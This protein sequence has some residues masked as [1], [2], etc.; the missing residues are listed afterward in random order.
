MLGI[1]EAKQTYNDNP[2]DPYVILPGN[3]AIE[4]RFSDDGMITA[5]YMIGGHKWGSQEFI[6]GVA[7]SQEVAK[8]DVLPRKEDRVKQTP[9]LEGARAPQRIGNLAPRRIGRPILR[10][11]DW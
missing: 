3:A 11:E 2:A 6:Q 5:A 10:R 9:Q 7:K 1:F 8:L 4:V